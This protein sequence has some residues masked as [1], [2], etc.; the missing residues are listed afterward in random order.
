MV[1]PNNNDVQ[2]NSS[3]DAVD[4]EGA[5]KTES[6]YVESDSESSV[7]KDN[8]SRVFSAYKRQSAGVIKE[9]KNKQEYRSRSERKKLKAETARKRNAKRARSADRNSGR[10]YF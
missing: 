10:K 5:L 2:E 8:F 4:V 7:A 9:F 1:S 6:K 3:L